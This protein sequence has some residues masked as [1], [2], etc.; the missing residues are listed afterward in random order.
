MLELPGQYDVGAENHVVERKDAQGA[1][2]VERLEG[3][4]AARLGLA[5]QQRGDEEPADGE[6]QLDAEEPGTGQAATA[7]GGVEPDHPENADATQTVQRREHAGSPERVVRRRHAGR[8]A[9]AQDP[10]QT[11]DLEGPISPDR[12][13]PPPRP[14]GG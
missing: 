1:A 12:E 9:R 8:L 6:E 13:D 14:R 3:D 4:A 2:Q 5:E 7:R 11:A 10:D